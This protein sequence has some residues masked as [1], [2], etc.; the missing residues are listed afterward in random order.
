MQLNDY[1]DALRRAHSG[2][3]PLNDDQL[4]AVTHSFDKPLWI[5]A[6]P[7]TGKTHT[8][9]WLVFKRVLV[10][11]AAPASIFLTTFTRKAAAELESRI[12]LGKERLV[13]AG[14]KAAEAISVSQFLIGTLHGLCSR[15]LQ[16]QR[17]DPTFRTRVLEDELTQQFFVRRSH[18]P[19]MKCDEIAFW[20]FF[21][22]AASDAKYAPSSAKRAEGACKLFNRL[23]ENS[24]DSAALLASPEPHFARLGAAYEAY[25]KALRDEHRVDQAHLQS[26]F[27]DYLRSPEGR[28]WLA[29]VGE[30]SGL[31]VIV[32]EYQD[33]NPI[34][35]AIYFELAKASRDVTV[36]G[37]DDQSLYRFRGAT[38][39]SLIDFD[40]ACRHFLG[41]EPTQVTLRE[42]RRS[43]S[44]VVGWVNRYIRRHPKMRDPDPNIRV[45]APNKD[46]LLAKAGL[47]DAYPGVM[48]VVEKDNPSAAK[49]VARL[50]RELKDDGL[51]SDYSQ[52]ALLS[53]STRETSMSIGTFTKELRKAGVPLYNPRNGTAH[54][55]E[56]FK[57]MLG[58]L[59]A[60]ID[61]DGRIPS[62]MLPRSVPP[63]VQECREMYQSLVNSGTYP[64]LVAYVNASASA[65]ATAKYDPSSTHNYLTRKGG[66]RVTVSGLLYKLLAHEPFVSNLSDPEAG[67]RLKA[68]NIIL[69]EYE[70][71]YSNGELRLEQL[72]DGTVAVEYWT[73]Y[74]FYAVFVEGIH[75]RLNDP[76]DDEVSV[77][78]GM[79]NVMT[80]HQSKGLEF[81]VVVVLR[82]DRDLWVN[83]THVMEDVLDPFIVRPTKPPARRPRDLRAAEDMVRLFFVA[84]SRAKRLLVI[85]GSQPEKW[86]L[87][88]G[89]D[90]SGQPINSHSGL[91]SVGVHL[92]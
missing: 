48:A 19:L 1:L 59:A 89:A 22:L 67:E 80:I 39:E 23:T 79:V 27:L 45:R 69:V 44:G 92:L 71:M 38:V 43:H 3:L 63:Y 90:D 76:E 18:N 13:A 4:K 49:K 15:I 50:V 26:H 62:D 17:Y 46:K 58:A 74:N 5:V 42:N 8:L 85:A 65:I 2:V 12:L 25:R 68:L 6:G 91:K 86:D 34:Q 11:G 77:Q 72:S 32:D 30:S 75:D 47:P 84:Y 51:V 70:S 61:P 83:D 28:S 87:A 37:D 81:E 53:F 64:N 66:R 16:D 56:R 21:G 33:T 40:R 55:D 78:P 57:A 52:I 31:K 29:E 35:E 24:I 14:V 88:L 54:K 10:D 7:G 36:V 20:Q 82:P 9:V 60:I 41:T 73:L